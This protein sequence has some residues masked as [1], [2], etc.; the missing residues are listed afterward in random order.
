LLSL[1]RC[2]VH[3]D[4]TCLRIHRGT[5]NP[6][7]SLG[8][9]ARV[10]RHDALNAFETATAFSA[11]CCPLPLSLPGE[12]SDPRTSFRIDRLDYTKRIRHQLKAYDELLHDKEISP[13][14]VVLM[15]VAT[16]SR[17][18]VDA[19]RRLRE[20][21][22]GTVGCINGQ[23]SAIGRPAVHYLHHF[24]PRA[25]MVAMFLAADVMLVTPLRDWMKLIAKEYVAC[26]HDLGGALV[27]SEFAGAWH[28]LNQAFI[29]NPHD[30]DGVKSTI[31]RAIT[32]SEDERRRRRM[33]G[34]RKRGA[35][36]SASR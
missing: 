5:A 27:L 32:S 16:P 19:Y 25:E 20:E 22:E 31:M 35:A 26:R 23:F 28:E 1:T 9:I 4:R 3:H 24:Y 11:C 13:P 21:V 7:S 15:Q 18:R 36:A 33:K 17:E 12:P 8:H 2:G 10:L 6:A 34:L 14:D 30:L 29:C